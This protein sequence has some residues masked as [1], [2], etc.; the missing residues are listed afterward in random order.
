MKVYKCDTCGLVVE[1]L[2][3]GV[4]P[5]CCGKPMRVVE[6]GSIDAALE[7]HVPVATVDGDVLNVRVGGVDHPMLEE[8]YI[9]NIWVEYADGSI[10]RTSLK[11]GN[12]PAYSFHLNGRKGVVTVYEYCN[13]HGL[14][15]TT[16]T[17]E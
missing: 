8:H 11:P 5:A 10:D 16:L 3:P 13:L 7:K 9:T 15:K 4:N 1:E 2:L 17:I 14:W 12:E 6:A